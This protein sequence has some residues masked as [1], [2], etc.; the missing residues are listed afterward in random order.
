MKRN[1]VGYGVCFFLAALAFLIA[2]CACG[3]PSVPPQE[4]TRRSILTASARVSESTCQTESE[5]TS[6]P[7]TA[8][9]TTAVTLPRTETT[10]SEETTAMP[11][12]QTAATTSFS[13]TT[14]TSQTEVIEIV[15][16]ERFENIPFRTLYLSGDSLYADESVILCEGNAGCRRVLTYITYRN[17]EEIARECEEEILYPPTDEVLRFGTLEPYEERTETVLLEILPFSTEEIPDPDAFDDERVL[18][19]EGEDGFVTESVCVRY[20]HG[21]EVSRMR[22]SLQT[23]APIS[24][25]ILVGQK[26][27]HTEKTEVKIENIVP[28][29][30]VY[31]SDPTRYEGD[32]SRVS[33][34]RDGYTENTYLITYY[35]GEKESVTLQKSVVV[36]PKSEV[37]RV[38]V[39]KK[40]ETFRMPFLSA[41]EG[42]ASYSVTQYYGGANSHGGIDFGV[43]YGAP[44]VAAMSGTV[45]YAYQSGSLPQS[46]L[47][48]TYGTFVVIEHENGTRTYYAHLKS[49][50]VSV[51][52]TVAQGQVIGYSGNTGR[53]SPAPTKANPLAGTHL[54]FEIRVWNGSTYVKTDPRPYLPF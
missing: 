24:A 33:A 8:A 38:G 35:H 54:H 30:T 45:V 5:A 17:G 7:E 40:E 12:L 13:E 19:R 39:K 49:R 2:L 25:Q 27:A 44:I 16:E 47:R 26:P 37:I 50:T 22:L 14:A 1:R 28:F 3:E 23:T 32:M 29:R 18:L 6:P 53:V 31:E 41:A 9:E 43:F 51:G 20:Y 52:D 34:G 48:W 46:D 36:A 21:K 10:T 42:G 4:S 11:I 15:T